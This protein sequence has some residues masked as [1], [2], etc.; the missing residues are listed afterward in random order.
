MRCMGAMTWG[1]VPPGL[2]YSE[3]VW[4]SLGLVGMP[5]PDEWKDQISP[6]LG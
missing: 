4:G 3:I 2:G 6:C 5:E 1:L